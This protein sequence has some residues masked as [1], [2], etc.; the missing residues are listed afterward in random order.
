VDAAPEAYDACLAAA[1]EIRR[2]TPADPHAAELAQRAGQQHVAHCRAEAPSADQDVDDGLELIRCED[3]RSTQV[4][5]P[6][7][8]ATVA[9]ARA[10]TRDLVLAILRKPELASRHGASAEL[11]AAAVCLSPTA[12]LVAQ[13]AAERAVFADRARAAIDVHATVTPPLPDLCGVIERALGGRA[14]CGPA[15][16]GAPQLTVVGDIAIA[17]IEHS[18]YDTTETKEYVAGIIRTPNPEYPAAVQAEQL[19][20]QAR[21]QARTQFERDRSQCAS[22]ESALAQ[23]SNCNGSCTEQH[24]RDRACN[25]AQTSENDKHG[26]ESAYDD[27]NARLSRTPPIDEREDRRTATYTLRHHTWRAPWRARLRNDGKAI[28]IGGE[29]TAT[30]LETGGAASASV[31]ADPLTPPGDR[32]YVPEVR[33]QVGAQL[34]QIVDASL[35]RRASDLAASCAGPFAWSAEYLECWARTH[36]WTGGG[37]TAAPDA[38]LRAATDASDAKRGAAWPALRC[39]TPQP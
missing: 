21:D 7:Y 2:M 29:A 28:D 12:D 15:H 34:A 25:L 27:A 38:L 17:A 19:A 11:L 32:W 35:R 14:A 36:F 1:A 3:A 26:K 6:A 24:E 13:A 22:A 23:V 33:E 5:T 16:D 20:R 37:A 9:A 30:D 4:A 39:A 8:A 10:H 18:A 31:P